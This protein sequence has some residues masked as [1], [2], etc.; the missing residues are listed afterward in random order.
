MSDD[1]NH[2]FDQKVMQKYNTAG[3]RYTSYPTAVAFEAID[4]GQLLT[5][6]L[7]TLSQSSDAKKLS[8]YMHIPFCH[9]LCYYCGCNK[10]VTRHADKADV[11]LDYLIKEIQSQAKHASNCSV[12]SLHL[13]GGTPSFLSP[14][15]IARLITATRAAFT[16]NPDLEMSIEV[17]PREIE[18]SYVDE[19]AALGFNRLSI[20]VQDIDEKVQQSINRVQ[21]TS[22]IRNLIARARQVGFHSVNVDLIYGLPHQTQDSFQSTLDEMRIMDPDRISLFSYAHMP[23]LFAAQRKIKDQWLPDAQ[24]KFALFR[25]AISEL[26]NQGYVFIGMDHFAKPTDELSKAKTEQRLFRNFQ[27]YTTSGAHATLG[28]GVS[29]I[30]SIDNVYVQNHKKLKDYYSAIDEQ[31]HATSKGVKLTEDDNIRRALI[32]ALM[33]NLHVNKQRFAKHYNIDFDAYF[34]KSLASLSPFIEDKLVTNTA[35]DII[36]HERGRLIVRNICMSFDQYLDKPLHQMRYSR[37]I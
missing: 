24:N 23:Q 8:L 35:E 34:A 6:A 13:G 9:S 20:G 3:P 2:Y 7:S 25:Q 31:G 11:Y 19:L 10:I 1:I 14:S 27:G 37:V 16:F 5:S 15:Q 18:L 36:I 17:D 28:L 33:C 22:F 32:H 29:S 30:S 21:S 4:D 12:D 26:T